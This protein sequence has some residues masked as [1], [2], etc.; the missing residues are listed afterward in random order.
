MDLTMLVF[1]LSAFLSFG[2][3]S[4]DMERDRA[5]LS[6]LYAYKKE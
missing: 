6:Y 5:L 2:V 3:S 1:L 4:V